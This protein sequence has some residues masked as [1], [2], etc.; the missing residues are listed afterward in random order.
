MPI[1]SRTVI[2]FMVPMISFIYL[3]DLS[4]PQD[5]F[6]IRAAVLF[7]QVMGVRSW[8]ANAA[9]DAS[10]IGGGAEHQVAYM[11]RLRDNGGR[12]EFGSVIHPAMF[13]IPLS[14][15]LQARILAAFSVFHRWSRKQS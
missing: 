13:L 2:F 10:V 8:R 3:P 5:P 15:S 4:T 9:K 1:C 6:F 14:A 12:I 7:L 11:E